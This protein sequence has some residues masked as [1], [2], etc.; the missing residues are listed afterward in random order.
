MVART[1]AVEENSRPSRA[2]NA[3]PSGRRT[4]S[5]ARVSP[6][7]RSAKRAA[8]DSASSGV[9]PSTTATIRSSFWGKARET[10][11]SFCRQR[12]L[13]AISLAVSVSMPK[14]VT[15]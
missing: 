10:A 6:R 8:P 7:S 5:N 4:L 1:C 12:T 9:R 11:I 14:W 3:P 13:G 2:K 15:A